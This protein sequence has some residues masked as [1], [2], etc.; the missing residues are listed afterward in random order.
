MHKD[1]N[2]EINKIFLSSNYDKR[3]QSIDSMKT[4]LYGTRKDL[5]CKK[6]D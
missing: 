4:Y 1:V 2:E 6:I 3:C 5:V